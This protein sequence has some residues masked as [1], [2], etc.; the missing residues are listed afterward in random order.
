MFNAD[1]RAQ[2]IVRNKNIITENIQ[3][4]VCPWTSFRM[5]TPLSLMLTS[6]DSFTETIGILK[7]WLFV[8]PLL[9][10]FCAKIK[11]NNRIARISF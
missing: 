6:K 1:K 7:P 9:L 3:N 2:S 11:L 5:A 10:S 8:K 4:A